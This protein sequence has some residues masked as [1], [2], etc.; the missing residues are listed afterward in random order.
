MFDRA[1]SDALSGVKM[2]L[3][4]SDR[5]GK[6]ANFYAFSDEC[7]AAIR[8][9]AMECAL[10]TQTIAFD[11]CPVDTGFMREH[12]DVIMSDGDRTFEIGWQAQD[13]FDAGLEFYP[14]FVVLGTRYM[15]PRDP[16]TP[17]YAMT[18]G[19]YE[20]RITAAIR[21]ALEARRNG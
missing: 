11:L 6:V 8:N 13:F 5:S 3:S 1:L 15:A 14:M 16:L 9:A 18:K 17:A 19:L 10:E 12:I 20:E 4:L 7:V 2:E 21:A